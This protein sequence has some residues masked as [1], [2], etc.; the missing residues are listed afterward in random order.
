[1]TTPTSTPTIKWTGKTGQTYLYYIYRI[2]S[3]L[4][5]VPGN[6]IFAK[7]IQPERWILIYGGETGDLSE[8]F[9]DH[10][11]MSCIKQNGATHIHAHASSPNASNRRVEEK[12]IIDRW[13]PI[14]NG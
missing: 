11:K 1:M 7:Q 2:G 12:D 4:K 3:S 13:N 8:R 6:Y 9:D 10:H 5:Q 14:C